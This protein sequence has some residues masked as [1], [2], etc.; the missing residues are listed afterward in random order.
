MS[1]TEGSQLWSDA[2]AK[3]EIVLIDPEHER[4]QLREHFGVC[5]LKALLVLPAVKR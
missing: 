3:C 1:S 5:A 4:T 2:L